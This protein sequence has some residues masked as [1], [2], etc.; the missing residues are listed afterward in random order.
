MLRDINSNLHKND[1]H[2]FVSIEP[3]I[4]IGNELDRIEPYQH[5][6]KQGN[7]SHGLLITVNSTQFVRSMCVY[8]QCW[9]FASLVQC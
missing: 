5:P 9:L 1:H 7:Q 3:L 6:M 4:H 2:A 8:V